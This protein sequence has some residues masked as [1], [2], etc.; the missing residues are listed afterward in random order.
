MSNTKHN[1]CA[2]EVKLDYGELVETTKIAVAY[3]REQLQRALS[4]WY[5]IEE[6]TK[7]GPAPIYAD[8]MQRDAEALA[9][10][11]KTL[12]YLLLQDGR[13]YSIV[14]APEVTKE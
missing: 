9:T 7:G 3:A 1:A 5:D 6:I 8:S 12:H 14:N 13:S 2:S 10:A 11:T 4:K